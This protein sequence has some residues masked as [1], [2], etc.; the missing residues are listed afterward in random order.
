METNHEKNTHLL[1][2]ALSN[3]QDSAAGLDEHVLEKSMDIVVPKMVGIFRLSKRG[4]LHNHA[5]RDRYLTS[6]IEKIRNRGKGLHGPDQKSS[7]QMETKTMTHKSKSLSLKAK[8]GQIDKIH[9]KVD[10][11]H[12]VEGKTILLVA[13][14]SQTGDLIFAGSVGADDFQAF[15]LQYVVPA[16]KAFREKTNN[17]QKKGR[18][19]F[20][21]VLEHLVALPSFTIEHISKHMTT[22]QELVTSTTN[23]AAAKI[24]RGHLKK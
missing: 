10:D 3:F 20:T 2:K 1:L 9:L 6:I 8:C 22:T 18:D 15:A 12:Y 16:G 19:S 7:L 24:F 5:Y 21:I 17:I 13:L 14:F 11:P 23:P 4:D